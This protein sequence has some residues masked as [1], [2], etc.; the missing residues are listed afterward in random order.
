ME[1]PQCVCASFE[2]AGEREPIQFC[3]PRKTEETQRMNSA[4]EERE[5][6][7]RFGEI[8]A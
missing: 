4:T 8:R 2:V 5:A 6:R 1:E 7:A 3:F